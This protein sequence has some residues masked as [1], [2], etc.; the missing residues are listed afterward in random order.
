MSE[1]LSVVSLAQEQSLTENSHYRRSKRLLEYLSLMIPVFAETETP[2]DG[3]LIDREQL[4][5]VIDVSNEL[6]NQWKG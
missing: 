5:D 3:H 2:K 4:I 1:E 6:K